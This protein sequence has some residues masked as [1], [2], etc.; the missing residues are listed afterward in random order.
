LW[1]LGKNWKLGQ[2]NIAI[3][4]ITEDTIRSGY[5]KAP[6]ASFLEFDLWMR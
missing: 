1:I 5:F 2:G 6:L 4:A 3:E